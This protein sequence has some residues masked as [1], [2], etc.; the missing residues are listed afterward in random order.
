MEVKEAILHR[1]IKEPKQ[2]KHA[3]VD[4]RKNRLPI[5]DVLTNLTKDVVKVY[6]RASNGYGTFDTDATVH[7]FPPL[8][9][10]YLN[11]HED[12]V[13]FSK[14]TAN[15]I[16]EKMKHEAFASG[17]YLLVVRFKSGNS[18]WLIA[19][20]LK[21]K[22]GTAVNEDTKELLENL[23]L[24]VDHLHEAARINI[25]KWAANEEPYLSFV[26]KRAGKEDITRYF[27]A[28]LGCTDYTH[29]KHHTEQAMDAI[30]T[31]M[32]HKEW[33]TKKKNE[34]KQ[35][36]HEYFSDKTKNGEPVNL[37]SLSV[38]IDDQNPNEFLEFT[39][40]ND[41]SINETFDAH[42]RTYRTFKRI[43]GKLGGITL[44]LDVADI[45]NGKVRYEEETGNII[46][47]KTEN[48]SIAEE[49]REHQDEDTD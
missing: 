11:G 34:M 45:V 17:G 4:H 14:I 49:I 46:I 27:R 7:P 39:K 33:D 42:P 24:D 30:K 10:K 48:T 37:I 2:A 19:A 43:S 25:P 41:Y 6:S 5:N 12:F 28:A 35:R 9:L 32:V 22:P 13:P 36:V 15:L 47:T 20:M 26:K 44:S 23:R 1:L 40:D 31:F 21:L 38:F 8:A 18:D 16:A 29:S 3:E